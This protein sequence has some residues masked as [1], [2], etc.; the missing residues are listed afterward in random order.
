MFF[1]TGVL[2]EKSSLEKQGMTRLRKEK[3]L[4]YHGAMTEEVYAVIDLKSFYA[5]CEC[6]AR[7]L[8]IFSTPLVV[9]DPDRTES[10]IVMSATPYLKQ[11]YG[12]PN[13]CRVRDLP[14]VEGMILAKPRM[15]YYLKISA[16]IVSLFL[17][18]V[19]EEDL[20]VYSIDE[21]FLRL[22]PYLKMYHC[23]ADELVAR[24]QKAIKDECGLLATAGMGPN[25][26]LA[27]TCLDNE[28][29]KRLPYRAYWG[30]EEV[31]T[32]LWKIRPITKVWGI[33]GGISRRLAKLGIH[34]LEGLAKSD[35]AT[36]RKEFGVI[37]CQLYDMAWG[38]DRTDIRV[39]Y[40]P[41]ERNLNQGQMLYRDY[42][43][44]GAKTVIREI[45]DELCV[46][47]RYHKMVAGCVSIWCLYS[48]SSKTEPFSRQASLNI[49]TDDV[50]QL[51]R[52]VLEVFMRFVDINAPIRGLSVTFSR[53][54]P[55]F[56][57][58]QDSL[59]EDN[60]EAERRRNL[61]RAIDHLHAYYNRDSVLRA[62][63]LTADSTIKERHTLIGGHK[64]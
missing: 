12:I 41:K 18:F 25:M 10:T 48:A 17:D 32:K 62:S 36:L 57:I 34:D 13:V 50:D 61:Y 3:F 54:E 43:I 58:S 49:P 44:A 4:F 63:A 7:G 53:L 55:Y 33:S 28:G 22:T 40:V 46:R 38:I 29:K 31:Q 23:T 16:K 11:K 6:A 52:A 59:F 37:G 2:C 30:K 24:I 39:K 56:G 21:S 1:S 5:S 60:E 8:D 19:S 47:L 51:Y 27:K 64:A 26:F 20:H 42:G 9:A 35:V 45:V 14:K 15:S